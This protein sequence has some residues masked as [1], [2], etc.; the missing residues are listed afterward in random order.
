MDGIELRRVLV[1]GVTVEQGVGDF[2]LMAAKPLPKC[3]PLSLVVSERDR[4]P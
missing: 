2:G 4:P 3:L 1:L